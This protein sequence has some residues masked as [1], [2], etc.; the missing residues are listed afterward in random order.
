MKFLR[1][2]IFDTVETAWKT[3]FEQMRLLVNDFHLQHFN[4]SQNL[5]GV[6]VK[7][8]RRLIAGR[9]NYIIARFLQLIISTYFFE[10]IPILNGELPL[11]KSNCKAS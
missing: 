4:N 11:T 9:S 10:S 6:G 7:S 3:T 8:M 5:C 2:V 1:A